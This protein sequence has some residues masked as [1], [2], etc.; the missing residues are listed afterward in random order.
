MQLIMFEAAAVSW[1]LQQGFSQLPDLRCCKAPPAADDLPPGSV[2]YLKYAIQ[3]AD[4][5]PIDR[6]L[7]Q[8]AL[9][10]LVSSPTHGAIF[11]RLFAFPGY[12]NTWEVIHA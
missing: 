9:E 10:P 6:A 11:S 7:V 2:A 8:G 3:H 12:R 4:A 1:L 5:Q